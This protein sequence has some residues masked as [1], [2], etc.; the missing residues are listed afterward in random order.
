MLVSQTGTTDGS[1]GAPSAA[2]DPHLAIYAWRYSGWA[3]PASPVPVSGSLL[4]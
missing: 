2:A 4:E 1:T 3:Q